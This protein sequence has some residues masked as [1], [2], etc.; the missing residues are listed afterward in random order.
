MRLVQKSRNKF[1]AN[2]NDNEAN[3]PHNSYAQKQRLFAPLSRLLS[4]FSK[5]N[6]GKRTECH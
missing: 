6:C 4:L 2:G 1:N 5:E 3:I